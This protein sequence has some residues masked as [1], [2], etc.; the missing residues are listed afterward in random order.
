MKKSY[1]KKVSSL[2]LVFTLLVTM[3]FSGCSNK[4]EKEVEPTTASTKDTDA[5]EATPGVES[6]DPWADVDTSKEVNLVGYL[7][8]SAPSGMD[9]VV[10]AL[11]E[12]LKAKINA[13]VEFRYLDWGD[14]TTKYP[15]VLA[16]GEDVDFIFTAD[17]CQYNT[18][19]PKNAF[20]EITMD[21]I[22]KYMPRHY[23]LCDPIAY[24]QAKKDGK[25]YMITTSTP[26]VRCTM[27]AYRKDLAD[28]YGI[29]NLNKLSDFT[30]YFKAIA[31]NETDV[32]PMYLSNSYDTPY[33]YIANETSNEINSQ[34]LY[35]LC[36]ATEDTVI[37]LKP[38][39]EEPYITPLKTAWTMMKDWYDA[40]Y[41]NKDI[42]SNTITSRASFTEG[43]SAVAF[44]N[45]VDMQSVLASAKDKGYEVGLIP[46]LDVQGKT[47]AISYLNNGVAIAADCKNP[48]RTM[49]M[50]DLIMEEPEI[51]NLAY[52]GIEGEN[53]VVTA[54]NKIG[55]PE[56]VTSENNTYPPDAS[57]LWFLNKDQH[58]PL[59]S[60]SDEYLALKAQIPDM[61]YKQKFAAFAPDLTNIQT[62]TANL[63]NV[64]Q[65]YGWPLNVG[66]VENVDDAIATLK[67][68]LMDAGIE[69]VQ[70]EI[71]TQADAF[72]GQ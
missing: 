9:K 5:A 3:A 16:T 70:K 35:G 34:L 56:G 24:E 64:L 72:M 41:V 66:M 52:F 17:W 44:G 15:L 67:K 46:I 48:E 13:T 18:E 33:I 43:K 71:Q 63:T 69:K 68:K 26:D 8:G 4:P 27:M 12:K 57:G 54:D 45:T 37:D 28:K 65:Q 50:L 62:E 14:Y 59:A 53:Y 6:T 36:Y 1:L 55:L 29:T 31:E 19:A 21:E 23:E 58:L 7:L 30:P 32:L 60:W 42:L 49:M 39:Y 25:I 38:S 47:M 61:I 2:L 22:Q 40:G 20:R 11:N 51:N 10:D